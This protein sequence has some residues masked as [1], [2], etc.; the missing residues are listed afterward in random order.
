MDA[1]AEGVKVFGWGQV[2]TYILAGLG[3]SHEAIVE[4][5]DRLIGLGVYPFVVPFVPIS[6][7][8]LA[9]HPGPDPFFM[10]SVLSDVGGRLFR[11]GM[12]S[13]GHQGRL[14]QVRGLL[15]SFAV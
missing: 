1:F 12:K 13:V 15:V 5:A 6:G 2:S 14:R 7:T 3:D 9:D 8:A 4:T 10:K 11:A